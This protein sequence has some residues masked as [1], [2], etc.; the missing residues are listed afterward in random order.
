MHRNNRE[1]RDAV[2]RAALE[3]LLPSIFQD[4]DELAAVVAVDESSM[5][6]KTMSQSQARPRPKLP[7]S[8]SR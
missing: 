8:T 3:H 1:L 7:G 4:H 5:N 2:A 6:A